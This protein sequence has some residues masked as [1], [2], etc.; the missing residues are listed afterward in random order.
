VDTIK[1]V[2]LT[3]D[4]NAAKQIYQSSKSLTLKIQIRRVETSYAES[5]GGGAKG[6]CLFSDFFYTS[7]FIYIYIFRKNGKY[8]YFVSEIFLIFIIQNENLNPSMLICC[9]YYRVVVN[10]NQINLFHY[11]KI[12]QITSQTAMKQFSFPFPNKQ[13]IY[14]Y[15]GEF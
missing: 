15:M 8:I 5:D 2:F 9:A 14:I 11:T 7:T 6:S 3:F 10:N 13:Y 1:L 12:M 4:R